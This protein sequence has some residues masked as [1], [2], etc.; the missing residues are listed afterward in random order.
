MASKMAFASLSIEEMV[1][2]QN[3]VT[4][5]LRTTTILIGREKSPNNL[6]VMEYI[7]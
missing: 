2:V 4:A 3:M 1:K 7:S 5:A 6:V